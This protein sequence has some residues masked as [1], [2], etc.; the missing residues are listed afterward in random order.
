MATEG[1]E[2]AGARAEAAGWRAGAA[3]VDVTPP[4]GS[5]LAGYAGRTQPSTHVLDPLRAQC[6]VLDDGRGRRCALITMDLIGIGH[7]L[8]VETR[9]LITEATGIPS[10]H[11]LIAATHTHAGPRGS[12]PVQASV[13]GLA[14]RLAGAA[15]A[16]VHALRPALLSFGS[17][18]CDSVQL[19]RRDVAG[20][21]DPEVAVLRVQDAADGRLIAA[22][23]NFACH[24]T[25]LSPNQLGIAADYPGALRAAVR[26]LCGAD[27]VVLF[28]N[29]ACADINPTKLTQDSAET[30]RVGTIAGA[31]AAR[32]LEELRSLH[33][34]LVV[35]T[36]AEEPPGSVGGWGMAR[37]AISSRYLRLDQPSIAAAL[38]MVSLPTRALP[39]PAVTEAEIARV[40][41]ALPSL[42]VGD[43]ERRRQ[44]FLLMR[45]QM[46]YRR[47]PREAETREVEVQ[48]LCLGGRLVFVTAPGE[49]FVEIGLQAKRALTAADAVPVV[50][51]Y[52]NDSAGYLPT[53]SAFDWHG[54]E[55]SV[56]PYDR[57]MEKAL[58]D[59]MLAVASG[60]LGLAVHAGI[61]LAAR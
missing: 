23:V 54:Y 25:I 21:I 56:S 18:D 50:V 52:A 24:P 49:L 7:D 61:S 60:A 41:E 39:E 10:D 27:A 30:R 9:S 2:R 55:V 48:G 51:G 13:P 16:A 53:D 46:E 31:E 1:S 28:A 5:V 3:E 17:G 36:P 32:V 11:A 15:R 22:L 58:L 26:A 34:D 45:L 6:L 12:H 37:K 19:N 20:P 35:S 8:V 33:G 40:R 42:P 43:P 38:R 14:Q 29:G 47:G 59:G 44:R 57:G 4:I